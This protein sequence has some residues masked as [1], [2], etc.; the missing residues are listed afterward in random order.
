[1]QTPAVL[2]RRLVCDGSRIFLRETDGTVLGWRNGGFGYKGVAFG[3]GHTDPVPQYIA[4]LVPGLRNVA[5]VAIGGYGG[6]ALMAD[7]RVLAWG[8]NAR[9][10][11]G[12]TPLTA[13]ESIADFPP[14]VSAPTPVVGI[15]DA[16][17][18][19]AHGHGEHT[20]A[21]TRGGTVFAWGSNAQYQLGIGEWPVITYKHRSAR[22]TQFMPYPVPIPGLSGVAAIAT[23]EQHSLA[24]MNDG[25]LRAWGFNRWGQ[26]GDGTVTTRNTPVPVAGI[27][28]AIAVAAAHRVSAAVLADG[29]VMTWGFG[30]VALGRAMKPEAPHPTPGPVPGVTGIRALALGEAHALALT[31]SATVVSWGDDTHGR[32]GHRKPGPAQIDGLTGIQSIAIGG[33]SS[34]AIDANG[35]IMT[36]GVTPLWARVDGDDQGLSR[37][38]I[39]LVIK[40]L[41]N[42]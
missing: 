26:L 35:R 41:K 16:V 11:V 24:L 39:P 19:S 42:L 9:G 3:L 5:D 4:F 14:E 37:F 25:T 36:W 21:L 6:C 1:M 18:I 22:P 8:V 20:L 2:P 30:T 13:F 33:A 38:P 28:N 7:G 12:N 27:K 29:T 17:S 31:N 40:G 15:I 34:F 32:R 10:G 23:A